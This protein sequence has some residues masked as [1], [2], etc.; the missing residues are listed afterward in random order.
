M[1]LFV[2]GKIFQNESRH[3]CVNMDIQ[4]VQ[5]ISIRNF[6]YI[7]IELNV[8]TKPYVDDYDI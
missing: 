3:N 5:Y 1:Y 7:K 6:K 4:N 2:K 8:I